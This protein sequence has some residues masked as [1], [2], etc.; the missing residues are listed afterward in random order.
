MNDLGRRTQGL[1]GPTSPHPLPT[2]LLPPQARLESLTPATLASAPSS[3]TLPSLLPPTHTLQLGSNWVGSLPSP[4]STQPHSPLRCK[5][6]IPGSL[7]LPCCPQAL[8]CALLCPLARF[9][10]A[11]IRAVSTSVKHCAEVP[12]SN[13]HRNPIRQVLYLTLLIHNVRHR[14]DK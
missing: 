11:W 12:S 9:L 3:Q 2:P 13:H 4:L 5:S 14:E 10:R 8:S 1:S 6:N 7:K